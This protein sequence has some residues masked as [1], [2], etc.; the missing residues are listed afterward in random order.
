M[1]FFDQLVLVL[2][3]TSLL[4][5]TTDYT[6]NYCKLVSERITGHHQTMVHA[7]EPLIKTNC[8]REKALHLRTSSLEKKESTSGSVPKKSL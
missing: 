1:V 5:R 4:G 6:G 3:Q 2:R 8:M 7:M